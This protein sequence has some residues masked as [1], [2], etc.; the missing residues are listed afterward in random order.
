[1]I[2]G[3]YPPDVW[4]AATVNRGTSFA[5]SSTFLTLL[6]A[7]TRSGAF[8]LYAGIGL[9]TI[10]LTLTRMPDRRG[11]SLQ[12]IQRQ[13][14]VPLHRG[15]RRASGCDAVSG[16]FANLGGE[17]LRQVNWLFLPASGH[18]AY[19][20]DIALVPAAGPVLAGRA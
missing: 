10:T 12:Q 20:A 18:N 6:C 17:P 9:L 2:P 8:C 1:M 11:R 7:L 19:H 3:I 14:G 13:L 5:V 15:E 4:S 16:W